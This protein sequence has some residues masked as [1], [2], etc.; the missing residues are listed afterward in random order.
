[1]HNQG[2]QKLKIKDRK[3]K[4]KVKSAY[5]L[6]EMSETEGVVDV[7]HVYLDVGNKAAA[8]GKRNQIGKDE[9][10]HRR[11]SDLI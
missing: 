9:M 2:D 10:S 11:V 7:G 5:L 8:K 4:V 3:V 6:L 1:L